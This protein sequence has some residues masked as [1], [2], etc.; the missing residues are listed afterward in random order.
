MEH[1]IRNNP[2]FKLAQ[3][4]AKD[5][6]IYPLFKRRVK[7][8]IKAHG[9]IAFKIDVLSIHIFNSLNIYVTTLSEYVYY[10]NKELF[11]TTFEQFLKTNNIYENYYKYLNK[12]KGNKADRFFNIYTPR[13]FIGAAFSWG[14]TEEKSIFWDDLNDKWNRIQMNMTKELIYKKNKS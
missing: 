14:T 5:Y 12:N 10:Q 9:I 2:F 3:R 7:G 4:C 11:L 8:Y 13:L 1:T 6:N